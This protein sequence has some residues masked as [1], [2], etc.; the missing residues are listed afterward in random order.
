MAQVPSHIEALRPYQGGKP[1]EELARE[2]GLSDIVKLASNENPLGPSPLALEAA[3]RALEGVHRYPDGAGHRLRT[4]IADFHGVTPDE[5]VQGNGSNEI[6]ELLVRTFVTPNDEIVFGDP[7]FAMYPVVAQ[8]QGVGF[9]KVK[10][11]VDLVHALDA[12]SEALGP[13]TKLLLLD[14]PNNPTGTYVPRAALERFLR[15]VPERAIVALDEAYFEFATAD[16]YPD[17]LQLRDLH[18]NIVVL[19]TFSKAY[20]LAG[21][22]VGYG[23][24]PAELVGYLHRV[25]APFNVGVPSQEAAIAALGDHQHL[26][27]TVELNTRERARLERELARWATRVFPSQA[28]FILADFGRPSADLNEALLSRGVIVRP[29]PGLATHLRVTVGSEREND[30]LLGALAEIFAAAPGS[31]GGAR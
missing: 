28:N 1:I 20:G 13:K 30:K 17:G 24:G 5:V 31:N 15:Q 22:R 4:A 27:R 11:T 26:Q 10:T 19:R 25:R 23:I 12:W 6:I 29:L 9:R 14:N 18:P 21:M 8:A 2:R 16:D 3:H 7:S